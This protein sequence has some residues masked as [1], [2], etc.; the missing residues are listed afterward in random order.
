[1]TYH[2]DYPFMIIPRTFDFIQNEYFWIAT[3]EQTHT[4]THKHMPMWRGLVGTEMDHSG[5][6]RQA[7]RR[8]LVVGTHGMTTRARSLLRHIR[9]NVT[10]RMTSLMTSSKWPIIQNI[11]SWWC[12]SSFGAK[13]YIKWYSFWIILC[14]Y[15]HTLCTVRARGAQAE[16]GPL[17]SKKISW[18]HWLPLNVPWKHLSACTP[19]APQKW[20]ILP[21]Y[22]NPMHLFW[23]PFFAYHSS[24]L[25][26]LFLSFVSL[27]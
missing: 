27:T 2:S 25:S 16:R 7:P 13:I 1:M 4:H 8:A 20:H 18:W 23:H 11:Y 24:T 10:S 21:Y 22:G 3:H 9:M 12:T 19:M 14:T 5:A 26:N 6:R 15:I 17:E